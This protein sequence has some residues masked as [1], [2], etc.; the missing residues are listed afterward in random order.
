MTMKVTPSTQRIVS[1]P[2]QA[3]TSAP[4]Q[5]ASAWLASVAQRMPR[6]IGQRLAI[7]RRQHQREELRL[8]ADLGDGNEGGGDEKRFHWRAFAQKER[9]G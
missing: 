4:I 1:G 8:V 2:T 3:A 7:A 5:A 9:V 6:M